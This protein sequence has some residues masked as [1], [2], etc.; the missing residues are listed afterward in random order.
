MKKRVLSLIL[1]ALMV[2]C[3]LPQQAKAAT[4][5]GTESKPWLIGATNESDVSAYIK[6]GKL[7]INGSGAMKDFDN[8]D[9][10][11]APWNDSVSAVTSVVIA[12]GVTSIGKHAFRNNTN[13]NDLTN[14]SIPSTVESIGS[15]AFYGCTGLTSIDIPSGVT[16]IGG[17][18]FY[19]CSSLKSVT[20]NS[21]TPPSLGSY[22]FNYC[23]DDLEISVPFGTENAYKGATNWSTH[24]DKVKEPEPSDELSVTASDYEGFY[25]GEN[26]MITWTIKIGSD[27]IS[28]SEATV[29]V[30]EQGSSD[31]TLW[32][33]FIYSYIDAQNTAID[34]KV[35]KYGYVD[36]LDSAT[37]KIKKRP[38]T[39]VAGSDTKVYDGNPLTN[40]TYTI[41]TDTT[42]A[43][44][45][46][47]SGEGVESV[48]MTTDSIITE[49]GKVDNVIDSNN[50]TLSSGT[51]PLNYEI[52]FEA[53]TLEVTN[54][55]SGIISVP[56]ALNPD[57]TGK[58][59][60]LIKAG[61]SANG[62][63]YYALGTDD[64][65]E[66][67]TGW[68]TSIPEATDID[69]YYVWY[70]CV[71]DTYYD[72]TAA[73]CILSGIQPI[74][75][76]TITVDKDTVT[77][78]KGE[79]ESITA[80]VLP[81]D[82]TE[83]IIWESDDTSV[84]TVD[85][86]GTITAVAAGTTKVKVLSEGRDVSA[87]VT[88]TVNNAAP[89][90]YIITYS[91]D[92]NTM[93][94]G[95]NG[96]M[97]TIF[98]APGTKVSF[99][100]T[101]ATGYVVNTV[102]AVTDG[103]TTVAVTNDGNGNYSFAMPEDN[104]TVS[105]KS[106]QNDIPVEMVVLAPDTLTLKP[107]DSNTV[108]VTV[109]PNNA[110]D[111]TLTWSID[112]T[113]VASVTDG[114]ITAKTVGTAKITVTAKNGVSATC[115]VT[116][117]ADDVPTYQMIKG[118]D[119]TIYTNNN[120]AVF[121]SDAEFNKFQKVQISRMVNGQYGSF[122]DVDPSNY[123][124]KAGSTIITFL[125]KYIKTLEPGKYKLR[126][127]SSDGYAETGF[128]VAKKT[129]PPTGDNMNVALWMML[130]ALSAA[131]VVVLMKRKRSLQK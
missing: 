24:A 84:A 91:G 11:R 16:S 86:N 17:S 7:Y 49:P 4:G 130:M 27:V 97:L 48:T 23:H 68:S 14:V 1:T 87:E 124:G 75:V 105:A 33:D 57:Y 56:K 18:V 118:A 19:G 47:I 30:R 89:T 32:D 28:N 112:N 62:T 117:K 54:A 3:L 126:I 96:S 101:A 36:A 31:W 88:V 40:A 72:D 20:M 34:V 109:Y 99:I 115:A 59:Q 55:Q 38:V 5:N 22:V 116:V 114:K 81:A 90:N 127:V 106:V 65:T 110:T 60:A 131:G 15:S 61:V 25:D 39:I 103:G 94:G 128:T 108:S 111:K 70:K 63:M 67:T 122:E 2:I 42:T 120:T 82:A 102:T 123:E 125:E 66:P 104:V 64:T 37:I 71:G 50:S 51:N 12:S 107:N 52:T 45:G 35:V 74:P 95:A 29:Y 58:A 69:T 80:T 93:F 92:D 46:F 113:E 121:S 129:Q 119:Q 6:N 53:G 8:T 85:Q 10:K 83:G 76:E 77:L 43:G 21:T 44:Y 73:Q 100:V 79:T 13:L 78:D 26:H 41:K 98:E 9:G